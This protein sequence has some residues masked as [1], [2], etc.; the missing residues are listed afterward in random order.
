MRHAQGG[1]EAV[2]LYSSPLRVGMRKK[3]TTKIYDLAGTYIK[4]FNPTLVMNEVSFSDKTSG[5]QGQCLL[6]LNLPINDFEEGLTVDHMH[7]VKIYESDDVFNTTPVLIY[8]GFVSQYVPFF[9]AGTEGV[10]LVLLGLV[11][12]LSFAPYKSGSSY[13]FTL[14]GDPAVLIQGIIDH[15]N[16]V[17]TGAWIGYGGGEVDTVGTS[18]SYAFDNQKWIDAIKEVAALA[19]ADWWWRI[20]ADGQVYLQDRPATATHLLTVGK[21]VEE[22]EAPKNNEKVINK[23]RLTWGS[24]PTTTEFE[25]AA[26]QTTYGLREPSLVTDSKITNITTANQKGNKVIADN[27]DAKVQARVRVNSN[28]NIESI[29]PGDTVTIRNAGGIFPD[30]MLVTAVQYTPDGLSLTLENQTPSLADTFVEA[31]GAV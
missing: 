1:A 10:R 22:G 7:V 24:P 4:T 8:T 5:G 21:N 3:F 31:V 14:S 18:V 6:E 17:Y 20:G 9:R 15:F 19:S 25:D 11:S 29:S 12:M 27:K 2:R 23:Y 26:S 13:A 16:S 30:N 28:Y